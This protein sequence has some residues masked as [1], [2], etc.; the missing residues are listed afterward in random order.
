MSTVLDGLIDLDNLRKWMDARGI[1]S[2]DIES[3]SFIAGGTQNVLMRFRRG[4]REYVFRR[5][6]PHKRANSD[7]TMRREAR[8]L[9]ALSSTNVP[10]PAL[11]AAES[12]ETILGAAFYLMEPVDGFNATVSVPELYQNN[13]SVQHSMGISM[14]DAIAELSLVDPAAVGILDLGKVDGWLTRQVGRWRSQLESYREFANYEGPNIGD[15]D[16]VGKWLDAHTPSHMRVGIMHGDYHFANVLMRHDEGRLAAIVDWELATIGDPLLDLGHV[17]ACWPRGGAMPN[18]L[19]SLNLPSFDELIDHY[20][21]RTGRDMTDLA[22]YRVLAAYR[23]GIILEGSNARAA[24]GKAPREVGDLLH[25]T[26]SALLAL[27]ED[28]IS[29]S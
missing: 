8:V 24:A 21:S 4:D 6:P 7:E 15:V 22:W 5:P 9:S 18:A 19:G 1:G 17:L 27:A 12:D 25:A 14:I 2:G 3:V 26:A 23:L 28:L 11:I 16:A 29:D 10:H 20:A 13:P